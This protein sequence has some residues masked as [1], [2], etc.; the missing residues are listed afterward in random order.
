MFFARFV[1]SAQALPSPWSIRVKINTPTDHQYIAVFSFQYLHARSFI[2]VLRTRPRTMS[3]SRFMTPISERNE[4]PPP[5]DEECPNYET[6]VSRSRR[7]AAILCLESWECHFSSC[8]LYDNKQFKCHRTECAVIK[9]VWRSPHN[10]PVKVGVSKIKKF[11]ICLTVDP[12]CPSTSTTT[13]TTTRT[14]CI[15]LPITSEQ[16]SYAILDLVCRLPSAFVQEF[17]C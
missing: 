3:L 16:H 10:F 4:R 13:T 5:A 7:W 1:S 6:A 12:Q 15:H 8:L 2:P 14:I 11:K 17:N 9:P